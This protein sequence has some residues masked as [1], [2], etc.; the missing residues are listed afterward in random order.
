MRV[1]FDQD[2]GNMTDRMHLDLMPI[3]LTKQPPVR[4]P[5]RLSLAALGGL[6]SAG[7]GVG[8][9]ARLRR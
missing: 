5:R 2:M 8:V 6:A 1:V 4:N 9:I 7:I 3:T